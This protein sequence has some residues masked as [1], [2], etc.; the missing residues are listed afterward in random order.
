M[1][2]C[3]ARHGVSPDV[4][5]PLVWR[6]MREEAR[7]PLLDPCRPAVAEPG[8]DFVKSRTKLGWERDRA[9]QDCH[10]DWIQVDGDGLASESGGFE[11][12]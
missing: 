3:R 2:G 7:Q 11:R 10:S 9:V 12:N 8:N 4:G 6:L 5:E 1:S